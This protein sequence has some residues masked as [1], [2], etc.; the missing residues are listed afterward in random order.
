MGG[1]PRPWD[2][3]HM[4]VSLTRSFSTVFSLMCT[5]V[6]WESSNGR[7]SCTTDITAK[8]RILIEHRNLHIITYLHDKQL[9]KY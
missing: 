6:Y 8:S 4:A 7:G 9:Y 2:F 1:M 5:P 3:P